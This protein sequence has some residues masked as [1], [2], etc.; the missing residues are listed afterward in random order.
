MVFLIVPTIFL[1]MFAMVLLVFVAKMKR[2][3]IKRIGL[4]R[5]YIFNM[6]HATGIIAAPINAVEVYLCKVLLKEY[7]TTTTNTFQTIGI[8]KGIHLSVS[9]IVASCFACLGWKRAQMF[10]VTTFAFVFA[11]AFP[12]TPI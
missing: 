7:A 11:V 10:P 6:L 9:L 1:I 3:R 12:S 5:Q 4:S 8:F 2:N